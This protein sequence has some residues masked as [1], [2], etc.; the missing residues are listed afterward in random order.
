MKSIA[1]T[2]AASGIGKAT[3]ELFYRRGWY[4]GLFDV[5]EKD[6]TSFFSKFDE[7]K[8]CMKKMDVA[9][10][11]SVNDAIRF[12]S[13]KT[14]GKM[15]VLFNCA[16]ILHMGHHEKI[17]L[18]IQ[19]KIVDI[20]LIGILNCIDAGFTTLKNTE[21]SR[22]INMSSGS[23][24]YG[25]PELAVYSSTKFAVRGLTEALNIEFEDQGIWVCDIMA[26]YVTTPMIMN[27]KQKA[28][29]VGKLGVR[30]SPD[31]VA[32]IVWKAACGRRVHWIVSLHLKLLMFLT[33]IG[34]IHITRFLVRSLTFSS[35]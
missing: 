25:T 21:N 16:G 4:V 13:E 7:Q 2:G 14:N 11:Q 18:K 17:P 29:S 12:F 23:A 1:I 34:N 24:V 6:L 9:D 26:P 20:N 5:N 28:S 10:P 8:A 33:K 19:K 31:Q 30:V 15:N 35:E 22:I 27:A 32:E 3:A